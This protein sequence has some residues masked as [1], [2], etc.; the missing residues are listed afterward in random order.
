MI[1]DGMDS[2]VMIF[3]HMA[4]RMRGAVASMDVRCCESLLLPS[5]FTLDIASI[6]KRGLSCRQWE[7]A[8]IPC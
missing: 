3:E 7:K 1:D 6:L 8:Q 4:A 5:P 2:L